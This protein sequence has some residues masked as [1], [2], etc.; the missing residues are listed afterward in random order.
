MISN[1]AKFGNLRQECFCSS[2]SLMSGNELNS[3]GLFVVKFQA[4]RPDMQS[5]RQ[6]LARCAKTRE[7]L[8]NL[9]ESGWSAVTVRPDMTYLNFQMRLLCE[10]YPTK[11]QSNPSINTPELVQERNQAASGPFRSLTGLR[12]FPQSDNHHNYSSHLTV[13]RRWPY[14]WP[15]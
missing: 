4:K 5:S 14:Q 12:L 1:W 13:N 9:G 8:S 11:S 15:V 10:A 2:T 3:L 6:P 7:E